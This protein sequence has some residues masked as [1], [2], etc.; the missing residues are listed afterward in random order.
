[1][2]GVSK[3]AALEALDNLDDCARM[4][5]GVDAYGP[6]TALQRFIEQVPGPAPHTSAEVD[7]LVAALGQ[8]QDL[9]SQRARIVEM[10][11]AYGARLS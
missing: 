1:M 4:Q 7:A 8:S 2:A 6:R 9:E 3:E 11:Q 10:L 5:V